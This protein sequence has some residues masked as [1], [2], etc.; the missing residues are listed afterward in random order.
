HGVRL[1]P[2]VWGTAV[3]LAASLQF[4][5]ALPPNPP[6]RTPLEPIMEFDRTEN[7]FRQAVVKT[8]L[9]HQEG[10]VVIPEAPGLGIEIDREALAAYALEERN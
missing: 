2:H 5:A 7:P 3:C 8:P 9:E 4:M 1:V 6:R 10:R